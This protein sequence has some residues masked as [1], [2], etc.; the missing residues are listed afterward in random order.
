MRW[1]G[2]ELN[3][4]FYCVILSA[5]FFLTVGYAPMRLI[6]E[7]QSGMNF[8]RSGLY[9]LFLSL[10][11]LY[12]N[13]MPVIKPCRTVTKR[14]VRCFQ[15]VMLLSAFLISSVFLV[16][17]YII[18]LNVLLSHGV[19]AFIT[20]IL[21][22]VAIEAIVFWNGIIRV[23]VSSQ[24]LGIKLR[25]IGIICGMIFPLN[26]FVLIKIIRT[27]A[28][29]VS[30]ENGKLLLDMSRKQDRIC[31]TRY[32]ILL[33]HGVFF[34]DFKYFNY[35]GR[36]PAELKENGA[37]IYYGNHQSAAAVKDSAQ[38]LSLR[39]RDILKETGAEKVNIIAH[40]KGG[41]DSRYA[42]AMLGEGERVASLTTVNTP[43]RGCIFADYLLDRIPD[44]VKKRVEKTYNST[45]KKLGDESPDFMAAVTDLTASAC[46]KFNRE[47]KDDPRV[48]YQS[49]GSKLLKAKGGRFPLNFSHE[50]VKLFDGPNDG[51]VAESSFKW[52]SKYT[53]LT[54]KGKRGISH[55]DVIDLNR[56]NI[57]GFDV[58]EFYVE[59]VHELKETGF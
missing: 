32:P 53:F 54:P 16:I 11:F 23:Y 52:G 9:V 47:V 39:I 4:R 27:A 34:R 51:L 25:A 44:N 37:K 18:N 22:S 45:L 33:V 49:I 28:R 57:E 5:A 7:E 30:F 1:E 41:L 40:S 26:L 20:C 19:L 50:L 59:L 14:L 58:R 24:Q 8:I 31:E 21:L 6:F 38:E 12:F 10:A 29:E 35:W 48:Y 55:G 36:I 56:E 46:E 43:H 13:I 3:D 15:G 17:F 2:L 42:I